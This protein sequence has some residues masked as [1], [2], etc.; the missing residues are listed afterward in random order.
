MTFTRHYNIYVGILNNLQLSFFLKF[1][2]DF[3]PRKVFKK[4]KEFQFRVKLF[5]HLNNSQS[6]QTEIRSLSFTILTNILRNTIEQSRQSF[7]RVFAHSSLIKHKSFMP[8]SSKSSNGVITCQMVQN[9]FL[10]F[11]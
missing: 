4:D 11:F 10:I 6:K 2:S 5:I 8:L 1:F 9:I 3:N 7:P